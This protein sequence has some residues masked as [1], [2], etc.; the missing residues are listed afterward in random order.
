MDLRIRELR[1][2]MYREETTKLGWS[3]YPWKDHPSV[4]WRRANIVHTEEH[5]YKRMF[6]DTAYITVDMNILSEGGLLIRMVWK[7]LNVQ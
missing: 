5:W 3:D 6:K 1:I 4:H 7:P 2:A